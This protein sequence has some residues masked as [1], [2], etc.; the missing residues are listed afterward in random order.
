MPPKGPDSISSP[1]FVSGKQEVQLLE[2]TIAFFIFSHCNMVF[3]QERLEANW[4]SL[5]VKNPAA[6]R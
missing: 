6:G 3:S 1:C 2:G 4:D 5:L